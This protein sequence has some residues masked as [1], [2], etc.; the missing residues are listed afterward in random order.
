MEKNMKKI[1]EKNFEKI[2]NKIEF[3]K[4][5][6]KVFLMLA[7]TI[8]SLSISSSF[9]VNDELWNFSNIYKMNSGYEIYKDLNVIITPL[10]F[11]IGETLF[12]IMGANY[13]V[14]RIYNTIIYTLMYYLIYKLFL[15][16]KVEK[17]IAKTFTLIILLP[18]V[19]MV[20]M[21]SNY[22]VLSFDFVLLGIIMYIKNYNINIK[23]HNINIKNQKNNI[24][25]QKNNKNNQNININNQNIN[26]KN[27]ILQGIVLFL[28]F[29]TKQNIAVFY[30]ISLIILSIINLNRIKFKQS[31]LGLM[32][33]GLVFI[34]LNSIF[35][36]Y[37]MFTQNLYNAINFTILGIGEFRNN[38]ITESIINIIIVAIFDVLIIFC[39]ENKKINLD[40][41]I[42]N[43]LKI[44][45]CFAIPM[46]LIAYPL[47]NKYHCAVAIL[48]SVITLLY[49]FEAIFIK[50]IFKELDYPKFI[51]RLLVIG[52]IIL[53]VLSIINY[54][55]KQ[56]YFNYSDPYYGSGINKEQYEYLNKMIDYIEKNDPL[57]VS[58][59]SNFF[60]NVLKK[61]NG[62]FDLPFVGNFGIGGEQDLIEKINN[63]EKRIILI[64]NDKDFNGF[65]QNSKLAREFIKNNYKFVGNIENFLLFEK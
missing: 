7:I 10:F 16:L 42:K 57:I 61:N 2:S 58:V 1:F 48:I 3:D 52:V 28:I 35:I 53:L 4:E 50:E 26:I 29:M 60:M 65:H 51:K 22:N 37:L 12:K 43:N 19:I 20:F 17:K 46:L 54:S 8:F 56:K 27:F 6:I 64:D 18:T 31:I 49:F 33:S 59:K 23:N 34:M 63:S 25:N 9:G 21:G 44:L 15:T 11:Y 24:K 30:I 55:E 14:F 36:T 41:S 45:I 39:L 62:V 38:I 40:K 47:F 32:I 5:N 13:F